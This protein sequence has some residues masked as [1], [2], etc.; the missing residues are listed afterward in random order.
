MDKINA[1]ITNILERILFLHN[2]VEYSSDKRV[3]QVNF[4]TL[5]T[6]N[7]PKVYAYLNNRKEE[8]AA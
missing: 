7:Q 2:L 4:E 6:F 3:S 1:I 8:L 5:K